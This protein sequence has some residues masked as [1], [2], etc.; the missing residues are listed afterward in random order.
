MS[1]GT[2]W[3]VIGHSLLLLFLIFQGALFSEKV[4]PYIPTLKVDLVGLPDSLKKDLTHTAHTARTK[5][6][7]PALLKQL[8]VDETAT[9]PATSHPTHSMQRKNLR[10]L[11][12]MKALAKIQSMDD[13]EGVPPKAA[14]PLKGNKLSP[15]SSI[16][17]EAKEALLTSYYD[18]LRDHLK[19][20]WSLPPWVARQSLSAQV[21]LRLEANGR[22]IQYSFQKTSGNPK[23][24]EAVKRAIEDS[25]PFPSPPQEIV[26]S[27]VS[28]GIRVGFPL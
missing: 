26:N 25:Q 6:D 20:N 21:L 22:I 12:R 2:R 7:L 3:S 16:E 4:T 8:E 24:D 9:H 19:N 11:E 23:F 18:T 1:T 28:D 5:K 15:G 10:A 27:L 17:G 13:R 14:T